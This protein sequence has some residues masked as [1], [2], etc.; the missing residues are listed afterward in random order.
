MA[1]TATLSREGEIARFKRIKKKQ[2]LSR[3]F[4]MPTLAEPGK[5]L[6]HAEIDFF[7]E[8]GFLI[9]ER[10]LPDDRI[11]LAVDKVWDHLLAAVPSAPDADWQ[12]RKDEP[13]SWVNP[14]WAK[15]PDHPK[16]GPF[17]GR[18]P[19]EH[20]GRIIKL[21]D[22]GNAD[23]LL[24]LCA[25]NEAVRAVV[26]SLLGD[27]LKTNTHT[28]GVYLVFPTRKR[29]ERLRQRR[30]TGA[31]LGPH[32]DQVCQQLNA[33]AYL[34]DVNGRNGGFTVYPGSHRIMFHAHRYEANWSP[35][36]SYYDRTEEVVTTIKPFELT[37]PKGSVIFWHGRL[38]HSVGIHTGDAIRWALFADFTQDRE[39]LD[40]D[41]HRA[42]G[43]YE[44]FKDAKLFRE[45]FEVT[46][47]MW[48]HWKIG[49]EGPSN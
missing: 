14:R 6:S 8:N 42:V 47:D 46:S 25:N 17:Q 35:L 24:A 48:R 4:E 1:K 27:A 19:I 31:L 37:A 33:C 3:V 12:L 26:R 29:G 20:Y 18:Q 34:S 41:E 23:Y 5:T 16:S 11:D 32:T 43:Q 7:L 21:H 39:T 30:S 13:D 40:D 9:K 2:K 36:P 45:D 15:Q 44:W 22:I 28:R 10:F 49:A 38:M